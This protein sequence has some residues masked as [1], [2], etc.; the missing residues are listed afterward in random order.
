MRFRSTSLAT[1]FFV[2]FF[3]YALFEAKDFTPQSRIYPIFAAG[4][5]FIFTLLALWLEMLGRAGAVEQV[6]LMDIAPD[7]STPI[8]VIR[9]R[10]LRVLCWL[11]ALYFGIWLFGFKI[12]ISVFFILFL[13]L[14]GRAGWL[15]TIILT[16]VSI[17]L[18]VFQFEMMLGIFWPEGIL[19][20]WLGSSLPWLF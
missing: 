5:G 16:S 3:G 1:A 12:A 17:Y 19:G 13:K 8:A 14:E 9:K 7:A 4:I 15:L 11:L 6:G 18:I 2:L 20:Q 10:A